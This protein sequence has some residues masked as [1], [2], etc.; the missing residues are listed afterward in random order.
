MGAH[1]ETAAQHNDIQ[2]AFVKGTGDWLIRDGNFRRWIDGEQRLLW[3]KGADGIGKSFLSFAATQELLSQQGSNATAYFYFREDFPYLQSV[4]NAVACTA[5]QIAEKNETYAKHIAKSFKEDKGKSVMSS[6]QRFFLSTFQ[7]PTD[8]ASSEF[9]G[10]DKLFLIL[11]GLDELP[12]EQLTVFM[13]LLDDLKTHESRVHVLVSSRPQQISLE[14]Y[15][16]LIVNVTKTRMLHD[17]KI[18]LW[19]RLNS[20]SFGRLKKFSRAAKKVIRKK[21]TNQ[22]DGKSPDQA[23]SLVISTLPL[24]A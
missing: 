12:A 1:K 19:N 6:W 24:K 18:L 9:T 15:N 10:I 16:P 21:I 20:G 5:L 13:R 17:I 22:A 4:Q 7:A 2:E 8:A 11:D 14:Q 23:Q 3:L